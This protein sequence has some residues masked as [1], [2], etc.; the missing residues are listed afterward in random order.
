MNT[1]EIT[2]QNA[3]RNGHKIADFASHSVPSGIEPSWD[4][5]TKKVANPLWI[6]DLR[7]DRLRRERDSLPL[8][9]LT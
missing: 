7:F 2:L 5:G 8:L 9:H 3:C 4:T 1:L 6:S